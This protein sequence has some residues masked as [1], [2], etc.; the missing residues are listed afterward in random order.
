MEISADIKSSPREALL[1]KEVTAPNQKFCPK[2]TLG[3]DIK[4]TDVLILSQ[5]LGADGSMLPREVTGLCGVQ[6]RNIGNMIKMAQHAGKFIHPIENR[7]EKRRTF[8][9][10]LLLISI[11]LLPN[12]PAGS[13]KYD[14]KKRTCL[15]N[16]NKYYNENTITYGRRKINKFNTSYR[17]NRF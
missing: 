13:R 7:N 3:L 14:P 5:Y 2:C 11:G 4:H 12:A 8:L 17:F 10:T 1:L 15:K 6:N 16:F 9:L